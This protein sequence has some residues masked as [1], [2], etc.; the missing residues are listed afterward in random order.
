MAS[1]SLERQLAAAH[2]M[3][4]LAGPPEGPAGHR[5]EVEVVP[6]GP[7]E[8]V[9]HPIHCRDAGVGLSGHKAAWHVQHCRD[10]APVPRAQTGV[11]GTI[12]DEALRTIATEVEDRMPLAVHTVA[13]VCKVDV[14][15]NQAGRAA[16]DRGV[17]EDVAPM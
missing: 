15:G 6:L 11:L 3:V 8:D 12:V 1:L 9:P 10:V 4:F 2:V 14:R 5:V 13:I 16:E 7:G 17:A